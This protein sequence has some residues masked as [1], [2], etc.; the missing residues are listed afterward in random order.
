M[1]DTVAIAGSSG[2]IGSALV[3][4]LRTADHRVL[5]IV[6]RT[7]ANAGELHWDPDSGEFDADALSGV[8]IEAADEDRQPAKQDAFGLGQQRMRPVD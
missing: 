2:L 6:R 7:P 3:T 1:A 8:E 4:A 5:R